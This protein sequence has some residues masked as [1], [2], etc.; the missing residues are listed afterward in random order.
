MAAI[1]VVEDNHGLR[2][3]LTAALTEEGHTARGAATGAA[4]LEALE[5]GTADAVVL[6]LGL[7]DMDGIEVIEAARS[8]GEIPVL[9]LT[10]RD[11]LASRVGALNAG[12][13]D[14]VVKPFEFAEV[15]ARLT[16]LL[17]RAAAPAWAP[18]QMGN[19]RL[20]SD[21]PTVAVG[22]ETVTLS[23]RERSLLELL[24]R[25]QNQPVPRAAILREVFGYDFDPG[26][27]SMEVHVSHLRR[28]L[29]AATVRI[30]TVRGIGYR[31]VPKEP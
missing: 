25:R 11:A 27:N 5:A 22:E 31:L 10:A 16:S 6:D 30:E 4:A 12:A 17:R 1:L 15:L 28:K 20:Q 21:S 19:V 23:P 24:L 26:T 13:D 14:Y 7:P 18:L 2:E 8:R 3:V 29:A 9:V